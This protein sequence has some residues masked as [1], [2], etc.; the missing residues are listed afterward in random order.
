MS[1]LPRF[2][3]V[4]E[5]WEG[6]T[7]LDRMRALRDLG[8]QII[9]FDTTCYLKSG[10]RI[11]RSVAHRFNFGLQ[12]H[13]LNHHLRSFAR[14]HFGVTHIWI[15]KGKWIWPSTLLS[16]KRRNGMQ[17]IHYTPDPAI[18]YHKSRYFIKSIPIYDVLFTTKK[19][20]IP[21][22]RRAGAEAVYLTYPAFERKRFYPQIPSL[23]D[24]ARLASDICL[25][26]H[27][28]KH[29]LKTLRVAAR[30]GGATHVWGPGWVRYS[31]LHPWTRE[32]VLSNGVW[33][34]QYPLALNCGKIL[35]GV[36]SKYIPE[37]ITTRSIEIPACGAFMLAERTDDHLAFF[38]EGKEAEFFASD[39][40]LLDKAKYYLTR[41]AKR[42]HI[43]EAA[44]I[45]C[46]TSGYDNHSRIRKMLNLVKLST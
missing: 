22:Y 9:S 7:C 44:R 34:D 18:L 43:G 33:G 46:L 45:R 4:G 37:T 6:G 36:L 13:Q 20:E 1:H 32:F 38:Q 29:Y 31:R 35:L 27:Y 12:I 21:L 14:S 24:R 26:G 16:L 40:E 30:T 41:D 39:E 23:I 42:K 3:Y 11:I 15:D 25:I 19:F 8:I 5:L 10:S 2:L 17:L 28:E